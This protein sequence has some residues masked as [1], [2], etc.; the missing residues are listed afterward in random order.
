MERDYTIQ[1]T[2]D[3]KP[4]LAHANA[5]KITYNTFKGLFTPSYYKKIILS[6]G[7]PRYFYSEKEYNNW[8]N[9]NNR[10]K[11]RTDLTERKEREAEE[12]QNKK[13]LEKKMKDRYVS[14]RRDSE[15]KAEREREDAIAKSRETLKQQTVAKQS[16]LDKKK[17]LPDKIGLRDYLFGGQYAKNLKAAKKELRTTTKEINAAKKKSEKLL[18]RIKA[19]ESQKAMSRRQKQRLEKYIAENNELWNSIR[20]NMT[21]Q[22]K[23][24][25]NYANALY[26]YQGATL[27]G[28][29]QKSTSSIGQRAQDIID[30]FKK[31][32]MK[33]LDTPVVKTS[34]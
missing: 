23:Q 21:K 2:P 13:D 6:N 17:A 8:V 26:Q 34:K 28:N 30:K 27:L 15:R 10:P 19:I 31:K 16:E 7:Q 12:A 32:T 3:G 9:R 18:R 1:V 33:A 14:A 5:A 20:E 22:N 11:N 25:E 4:Y 29:I 24:Q